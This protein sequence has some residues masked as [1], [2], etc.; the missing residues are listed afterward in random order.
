MLTNAL[1]ANSAWKLAT[2]V[3][4]I[5]VVLQGWFMLKM[6]TAQ[7]VTIAPY[8]LYS[9]NKS[10][11]VGKTIAQNKDYLN[12]LFRADIEMLLNWQAMTVKSQFESFMTRLS[13]PGYESY[14]LD[15]RNKAQ[16]YSDENMSQ[17]FFIDEIAMLTAE[18]VENVTM[19]VKGNLVRWRGD[20]EIIDKDIV[21]RLTYSQTALGLFQIDEIE[22]SY[23]KV[24]A[25]QAPEV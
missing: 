15:L 11:T 7:T 16:R 21:Y 3:L 14:N 5:V 9:A 23:E 18:G 24:N 13:A 10:V 12:L 22:A 4:A 20:E 19:E 17:T 1:K 6:K 8:G 25:Q 2:A